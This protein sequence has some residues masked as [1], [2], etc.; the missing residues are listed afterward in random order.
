MTG[1]RRVFF[2]FTTLI[3]IFLMWVCYDAAQKRKGSVSIKEAAVDLSGAVGESTFDEEFDEELEQELP[4]E[5]E[6][7]LERLK[8]KGGQQKLVPQ[9][10][11]EE[12]E[13]KAK[14]ILSKLLEKQKEVVEEEPLTCRVFKAGR[15][16]YEDSLPVTGDIKSLKEIKMRF[17]KEGVIEKIFVKEGDMVKK[18]D[19]IA[20]LNKK[21]S[22]LAVARAKS[23]LDS[24]RAALSAA[25]KELE[26]TEILYEKGAIIETKL[27]EVKFRVESERS[28]MRVSEEELKMAE[29]ALEKTELRSSID[30]VIGARGA[31]EGEFF[32]PRDTVVNLL[33]TSDIYVEVGIVERDIHK[34]SIGQKALVRVDAYP[35]REFNG[36]IGNLYPVVEG[37]SRTMKA[38]I[39]IIDEKGILLPGMFAQVEIFLAKFDAALMVP[40]MG[41]I[42]MSPDVTVAALVA[43]DSDISEEMLKEGEGRGRIE[44]V[45][46]NAGYVGVDYTQINSG[47]K[48]GDFIVLEAHGDL[49]HDRRVRILGL[50]EYGLYD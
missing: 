41:L 27:E 19:L 48:E 13:A 2:I 28:K 18:G 25:G 44:L 12:I 31:E 20:E 40:T 5:K 23:K 46:V 43:L 8:A 32:T 45:E 49:E 14:D 37:R 10:S 30:G 47:L 11:D 6:T 24:D 50:E 26:L 3:I 36:H 29:S 16:K 17:E 39:N 4:Q 7:L 15:V 38:E 1:K 33:G 21:D 42:Q 22:L 9:E 35:N 34:V